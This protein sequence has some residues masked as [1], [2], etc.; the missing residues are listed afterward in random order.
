VDR[1]ADAPSP[2]PHTA[3]RT[4]SPPPAAWFE[5][6][7]FLVILASTI[8]MASQDMSDRGSKDAG[9]AA[10]EVACTALF[11]A[12]AAIKIIDQGFW[13]ASRTY[14]RSG[15]NKFDLAL[16]V[17][18]LAALVWESVGSQFLALRAFR[19]FRPLRAMKSFR[20]GQLLMRTS[21]TA[22]P[23]LRDAIIFLLW[24]V[25]VA[26]CVGVM[27]FGGRLNGRCS[28]TD[29]GGA[30]PAE[31][32]VAE[33]GDVCDPRGRGAGC[34]DGKL[35][36]ASEHRP[37][38][39]Y[40][41]FDDFS[42]S[43]ILV[44]QAITIDGW[45]EVARQAADGAGLA[46]SAPFFALIVF[47]GG[48]YVLQLFASVM[49]ITLSHCTDQMVEEDEENARREALG[50]P[51]SE[52][53]K[54]SPQEDKLRKIALW[55]NDKWEKFV[56]WS[57]ENMEGMRV[58][59]RVGD[60]GKTRRVKKSVLPPAI[61]LQCRRLQRFVSH[62]YFQRFIFTIII[63]NT[64]TMASNAYG[65][66]RWWA[67]FLYAC[68]TT[69]TGIFILEFLLKHLAYGPVHYW[70][71]RWNVIDGVVVVAGIVELA[72]G[73]ESG[74]MALLRML[75]VLRIVAGLKSLRRARAFQQVFA[76]IG[77]GV[78]R[79]ASFGIIFVMFIAVFAI[80]GM[81]LFGGV[82]ELG[83]SRYHF[84]TFGAAL[85]TLFVICTGENTF[86]VAYLMMR[87]SGT[88][89]SLFYIV[90]WSLLSTSLLA[91]VLGVLIEAAA[92]PL[93]MLDDDEEEK[94]DVEYTVEHTPEDGSPAGKEGLPAKKEGS[95]AGKEGSPATANWE[96]AKRKA[97]RGGE[98]NGHDHDHD[99]D[100]S[101]TG[102]RHRRQSSVTDSELEMQRRETNRCVGL[103]MSEKTTLLHQSMKDLTGKDRI[104]EAQKRIDLHQRQFVAETAAVRIWLLELDQMN[105][106]IHP[107]FEHR[108]NRGKALK[109]KYNAAGYQID[110]LKKEYT[111]ADLD[112]ARDRLVMP[113]TNFGATKGKSQFG[114]EVDKAIKFSI[115]TTMSQ[116]TTVE[117]MLIK[118][119]ER[120]VRAKIE[121]AEAAAEEPAKRADRLE[122]EWVS[123]YGIDRDDDKVR[124][125]C[126]KIVEHRWF[127]R[128][129]LFLVIFSSCLLAPECDPDWPKANTAEATFVELADIFFIVIF[130]LEMCLKII[131]YTFKSGP[132]AYT[133]DGWNNLDMFIVFATIMTK[134]LESVGSESGD[135]LRV[136]RVLRVLRPLRVIKNVPSLKLVIDA[137]L[138][139]LPSILTVCALGVVIMII[140]G[141][142]GMTLFKGQYYS[143]TVK[144]NDGGTKAT[145]EAAGGEWLNTAINFDN[146]GQASVAI[147]IIST[148][149]NWQ[150]IMWS[151]TDVNGEL[152]E[153]VYKNKPNNAF[154]FVAVVL[155]A[156]FF[157]ANL[158]VSSLVD[159]F[160]QVASKLK[161]EEGGGGM[162]YS[163]S[164][165]QR[166]WFQALK[167]A[168]ERASDEWR[169]VNAKTLNHFRRFCLRVRKWK[170]WERMVVVVLL[171]NALQLCFVRDDPSA[172]EEEIMDGFRIGFTVLYVLET[173]VN[174][175]AMTWAV[176]WES[177]WH[178][179]DFVVT[180]FGIMELVAETSK[181]NGDMV[182]V[183]SAARFFRLVKVLKS[184]AGLRTLV[185]TFLSA[186]PGM[187]NIFFLML[188]LMHIYAC[189][190][191]ALYSSIP[192]YYDGAN[193]FGLTP[194]TNFQNWPNA[195]ALLYVVITGNWA[196][197][198]HDVYW[199]C[200]TKATHPTLGTYGE[201]C[202][203]RE[204]APVYFFTFVIFGICLLC[205]LFVAIL[206]ERYDY[207]STMEGVYDDRNPFDMLRRL[208]IL[209]QFA[210]K[211][212]NRMRVRRAEAII[213]KEKGEGA[214]ASASPGTPAGSP[215]GGAGSATGATPLS[216]AGK[217]A[218]RDALV[219]RMRSS[220]NKDPAFLADEAMGV[221]FPKFA[222][223]PL[224][225][226]GAGA[227]PTKDAG[228]KN[229][230]KRRGFIGGGVYDDA[231]FNRV[232]MGGKPG[233]ARRLDEDSAADADSEYIDDA[234]E[235]AKSPE[236]RRS[237]RASVDE[238]P[239]PKP[240]NWS[241]FQTIN[242]V[243]A[244]IMSPAK[245]PVRYRRNDNVENPYKRSDS[246]EDDR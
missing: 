116:Y 211:V 33:S 84:D 109:A 188:L 47:F 20:D 56:E 153:P 201:T 57:H 187:S 149:D 127:K 239:A 17:G 128:L 28:A 160:S 45:N 2:S 189:L 163:Y 139:S 18:A 97:L 182:T 86:E 108:T 39:D 150:D 101:G 31:S 55:V 88:Y 126:L 181:A 186:I 203:Y 207:S 60:D 229:W 169:Y 85:L 162:G 234:V 168:T 157:W 135:S 65:I 131:A 80:L 67:F 191:C 213:L 92:R 3:T 72:M 61:L 147:F 246:A 228:M 227:T 209:R 77:N 8:V 134:S 59:E 11:A 173:I 216:E 156:F 87:E 81:Q 152:N 231:E 68:E 208:N 105:V 198:F 174:I 74:A 19:C 146:I 180:V 83:E 93:A 36:C 170:H 120:I 22:I 215:F 155:I 205:N 196:G 78:V 82:G 107:S 26:T 164:E 50:L 130:A 133:K 75:R 21:Y 23:L 9:I 64:I 119:K 37:L 237:G 4:R 154:Y 58:E 132:K 144:T 238:E 194:Y 49:I 25:V 7:I 52:N 35:C 113:P 66:S 225:R 122:L 159:N 179:I 166:K 40:V 1:D 6:F 44:L 138:V 214:L 94:P 124:F 76:A 192:E 32:A 136:L 115:G 129:I 51:P 14:M 235:N 243:K 102:G 145:C 210:Y 110:E 112:A 202:G 221:M 165:S 241:P 141:V 223:S 41:S 242:A 63:L 117:E 183:F 199:T 111:S 34:D 161:G 13:F 53:V 121:A 89:S 62:R 184:S 104:V 10:F 69:F 70:L 176:Y 27:V 218:L 15:W 158:F 79:M 90:V 118:K 38:E 204:T 224:G 219:E 137:T 99:D 54:F 125:A 46:R 114:C 236:R 42:E 185:D 142:L 212:R 197:S 217:R 151:G 48:F 140:L 98:V 143:C 123:S 232:V 226:G 103:F 230:L 73:G 200:A 30:C 245:Q 206:L 177:T 106:L 71:N 222:P 175:A 24:F 178:K 96:S 29:G 100:G 233:V 190:G 244:S 91:L 193:A 148:G 16:V 172:T 43:V 167:L 5:T 195:I 220:P 240:A 12:E 95:P 171:G